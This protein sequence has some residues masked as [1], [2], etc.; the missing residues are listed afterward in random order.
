M[1]AFNLNIQR[2][3]LSIDRLVLDCCVVDLPRTSL[4]L[5][6]LMLILITLIGQP[7]DIPSVTGVRSH[8]SA[9]ALM[10]ACERR[11]LRTDELSRKNGVVKDCVHPLV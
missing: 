4:A 7:W 10:S 5:A 1:F 11:L 6:A 2:R 8:G 9:E 3:R